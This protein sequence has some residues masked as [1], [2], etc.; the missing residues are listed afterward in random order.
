MCNGSGSVRTEIRE[1]EVMP[2]HLIDLNKIPVT[3]RSRV[4]KNEFALFSKSIIKYLLTADYKRAAS[5]FNYL[6]ELASGIK[7]QPEIELTNELNRLRQQYIDD[8][9]R[10]REGIEQNLSTDF[11]RNIAQLTQRLEQIYNKYF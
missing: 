1:V 10:S 2:R 8:I 4:N 9:V 7:Q 3:I 6:I 5:S 11:S